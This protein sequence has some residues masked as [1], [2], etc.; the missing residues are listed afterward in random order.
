[1][2]NLAFGLLPVVI[3]SLCSAC[4]ATTG[5]RLDDMPP[6]GQ[7]S[8]PSSE[9][10]DVGPAAGRP[11]AGGPTPGRPTASEEPERETLAFGKSYTWDDGVTVTVGKP[12]RFN[13][14]QF[15]LVEKSKRYVKF[16]VSVVNRS[17][18]PIDLGRTY[19]SVRSGNDE[20]DQLF[21]VGSGLKGP[22]NTR[23]LKARESEFDVGFGVAD[24]KDLVMELALH[25]NVERPSLLYST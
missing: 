16:T 17:D 18:R 15:A 6:V 9:P 4:L 14:S 20:A 1:V 8:P 5:G 13:P 12:K 23:V 19:I 24:P 21:D 22:P 11:T 2:R 25:D 10:T 3:A 7:S